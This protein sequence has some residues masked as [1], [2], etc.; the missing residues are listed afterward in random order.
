MNELDCFNDDEVL[1]LLM[2]G[3]AMIVEN[4]EC[5]IEK[6]SMGV[7]G[8]ALGA[9]LAGF[10]GDAT[11]ALRAKEKAEREKCLIRFTYDG[12]VRWIAATVRVPFGFAKHIERLHYNDKS[13]AEIARSIEQGE[14]SI[15]QFTG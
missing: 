1:R 13:I 5:F 4:R 15:A 2:E 10:F 8:C 7:H 14:I 12:M 3:S 6:T 9:M 11:E